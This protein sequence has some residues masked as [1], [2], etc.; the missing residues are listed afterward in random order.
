MGPPARQRLSA[1]IF[2]PELLLLTFPGDSGVAKNPCTHP[3]WS[4]INGKIAKKTT[5][6]LCKNNEEGQIVAC[7]ARALGQIRKFLAEITLSNPMKVAQR[8]QLYAAQADNLPPPEKRA[9]IQ[10]LDPRPTGTSTL[11]EYQTLQ[12]QRCGSLH[13]LVRLPHMRGALQCWLIR[14]CCC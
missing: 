5:Y 14:I 1:V 6:P 3:I 13:Y 4:Q 10:Q 7:A 9:Q 2:L 12:M 8:T 11:S